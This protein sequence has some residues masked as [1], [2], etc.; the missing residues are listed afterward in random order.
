MSERS[1]M[2]GESGYERVEN[3]AYFTPA[4]CTEALLSTFSP[5][6]VW[7]PACGDGAILKVCAARG[8]KAYGSDIHDYG[9]PG[10]FVTDFFKC[11][12]AAYPIIITNPPY[13]SARKFIEHAL[14]LTKENGGYVGMLLR[15]EFDSAGSRRHLFA[16]CPSFKAKYVLTRRPKWFAHEK[17][18]PR[19][20]FSWF[21]W[22]WGHYGA[23]TIAYLP[24]PSKTGG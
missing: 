19:H 5:L 18:A 11:E 22:Q 17:A 1:A 7:D 14:A 6:A 23:P 10:T 15:N 4:W 8:I 13:E 24:S 9:W 3:D 2:H 16:D 21:V 20:N 12:K